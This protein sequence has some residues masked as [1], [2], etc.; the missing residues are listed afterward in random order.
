[1][2]D[3]EDIAIRRINELERELENIKGSFRVLNMG[4]ERSITER[5]VLAERAEAAESLAVEWQQRHA[6]LYIA[7][8]EYRNHAKIA[9]QRLATLQDLLRKATEIIDNYATKPE[10]FTDERTLHA[11]NV[12]A[13]HKYWR[14]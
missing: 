4:Y 2:I 1:M 14:K 5:D 11:G 8:E 13:Q 6:D 7:S 12:A 3:P 9:E 10:N